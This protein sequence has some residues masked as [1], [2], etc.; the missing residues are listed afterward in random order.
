MSDSE[1]PKDQ[2]MAYSQPIPI[3]E[4]GGRNMCSLNPGGCHNLLLE[5]TQWPWMVVLRTGSG[6][7]FNRSHLAKLGALGRWLAGAWHQ[8]PGVFRA[9]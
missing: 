7:S 5:I 4:T 3:A 2:G 9:V 6:V 1:V 8:L